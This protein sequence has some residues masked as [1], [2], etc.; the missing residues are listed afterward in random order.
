MLDSDKDGIISAEFI[1]IYSI[2]EEVLVVISP[3]LYLLEE[4]DSSFNEKEFV[5]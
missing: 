4:K 1:D 2:C 5:F 3:I